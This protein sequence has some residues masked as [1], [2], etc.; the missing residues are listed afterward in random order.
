MDNSDSNPNIIQIR[1]LYKSGNYLNPDIIQIRIL[2]K[3]ETQ[4]SANVHVRLSCRVARARI[5]IWG[6]RLLSQSTPLFYLTLSDLVKN[7]ERYDP[8]LVWFHSKSSTIRIDD[9]DIRLHEIMNTTILIA[10]PWRHNNG[11]LYEYSPTLL[12]L[13]RALEPRGLTTTSQSDSSHF[14]MWPSSDP[15]PTSKQNT[16]AKV[17]RQRLPGPTPPNTFFGKFKHSPM[18]Q[19]KVLCSLWHSVCVRMCTQCT[20]PTFF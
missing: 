18:G 12:E 3:A 13:L 9:W 15:L 7:L 11:S 17:N 1:I 6:G 16:S 5:W 2:H 19:S 8:L 10:R 4:L 20:I 14:S